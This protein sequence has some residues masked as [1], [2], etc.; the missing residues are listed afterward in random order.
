MVNNAGT[1]STTS[2]T[3]EGTRWNNG[4]DTNNA[5]ATDLN[6]FTLWRI[7]VYKQKKWRDADLSEYYAED[8][9][10]FTREHFEQCNKDTVRDLRDHLRQYGVYV[11]KGRGCPIAK[12]LHTAMETEL[13]WPKDDPD[14]PTKRSNTTPRVTTTDA[15]MTIP[16]PEITVTPR[17]TTAPQRSIRTATNTRTNI[18][19]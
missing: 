10:N 2:P 3:L 18:W 5:T 1:S 15:T 16:F 6:S 14:P 19:I 7:D 13:E 4:I 17:A 9:H 12:E 11:R 8:F